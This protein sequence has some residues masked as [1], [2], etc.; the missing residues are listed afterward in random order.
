MEKGNWEFNESTAG[1]FDEIAHKNIPHYEEVITKAVLITERLF[2]HKRAR[3]IDVGSATGY[4][5]ERFLNAGFE[6]VHGVDNS[7]SML[8]QSRVQKNLIHSESFPKAHGPFHVVVANWTLHFVNEREEY[9]TDIFDALHEDGI[10]FLS[11]KMQSSDLVH[12]RYHD[13]KRS[14]GLTEEQIAIKA[15]AIEGVLIPYPL[16]WYIDTLH[17]IG[18]KTVEIIDASWCFKSLL[19][20][21]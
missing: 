21:K 20:I 15:A 17:R 6:D 18:F 1:E 11:D 16:N 8:R 13:F 19:C 10:L 3:V 2:P 4:T 9:L 14:M 12:D 7:E 5:M